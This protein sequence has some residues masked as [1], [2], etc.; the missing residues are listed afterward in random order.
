MAQ[1]QSILGDESTP[2]SGEKTTGETKVSERNNV[3][4]F[5]QQNAKSEPAT[6]STSVGRSSGTGSVTGAA[7]ATAKSLYDQAKE[8]AGQAY[9]VV[10][11]KAAVKFDEQKT[12]LSDGLS[13]VAESVR[14]VGD[15]LGTSGTDS[16]IAKTAADYTTT[17]ARKI[18]DV[19]SY[20]ENRDL[21]EIARDIEGFARR[22]PAVFLGAAFGLGFLAAR[23]FKSSSP[24]FDQAGAGREFAASA[25]TGRVSKKR[26]SLNDTPDAAI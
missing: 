19:A 17:A 13:T 2:E 18:E 1:F 3:A 9:E 8:T 7:T 21:R 11:D 22:N 12:T 10:T 26:A 6:S 20:F 5:N 16:P 25:D 14:Q 4:D 15:N 24:R 23:F